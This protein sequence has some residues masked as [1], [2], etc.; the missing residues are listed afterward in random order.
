VVQ[1][2]K[3]RLGTGVGLSTPF[4]FAGGAVGANATVQVDGGTLGVGLSVIGVNPMELRNLTTSGNY[5]PT[6]SSLGT[7]NVTGGNVTSILGMVV[8]GLNG[9]LNITGGNVTA[10]AVDG[11]MLGL[12][13]GLFPGATGTINVAGGDLAA[14]TISLG[15]AGSDLL[16]SNEFGA[17]AR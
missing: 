14:T 1:G 17:T 5:T 15:G 12:I 9:Q 16:G 6:F 11:G 7:M 4:L 8:G 13:A 3:L 10:G 2:G